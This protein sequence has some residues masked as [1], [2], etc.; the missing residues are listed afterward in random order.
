[1]SGIN[2]GANV[3]DVSHNS[4]TVGAAMQAAMIGTPSIAASLDARSNDYR[5]AARYT[6]AVAEAAVSMKP[7]WKPEVVHGVPSG[8]DLTDRAGMTEWLRR[9]E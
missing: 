1:M 7:S 3:G 4:G 9:H 5:V 2:G 6:T 8:F